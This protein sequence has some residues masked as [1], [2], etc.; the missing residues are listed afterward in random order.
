MSLRRLSRPRAFPLLLAVLLA[1]ATY[2]PVR[3]AANPEIPGTPLPPSGQITSA[4]GGSVFDLVYAVDVPAASVL[5]ISLRG[6][7]G[8]E[9]GLYLFGEGSTSILTALPL[10]SSAKPGG[11]QSVSVRFIRASTVYINVNGR[12][13]NRAYS[14]TL[15]ASILRDETPPIII[16]AV[17]NSRSQSSEV[18][19]AVRSSDPISGITGIKLTDELGGGDGEWVSFS[20]SA[21]HCTAL[22]EGDGL[23]SLTL[24]TRNGVNLTSAAY[25]LTTIIDDTV[26]ELISVSPTGNLLLTARG[27]ISWRFDSAITT[28]VPLESAVNIFNQAGRVIN[29]TVTR[30]ADRRSVTWTPLSNIPAGNV[31]LASLGAVRDAAGNMLDF[32]DT[33]VITRKNVTTL[34]ITSLAATSKPRI[35]ISASSNLLGESVIIELRR[36]RGWVP[37]R[38]VTLTATTLSVTLN[39]DAGSAVRASFTGSDRLAP[40]ASAKLVIE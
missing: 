16:S 8:A 4:V 6:E 19:V 21:V 32:T 15:L 7:P 28:I 2:A 35:R 10:A 9:L 25:R 11:V 20:G 39:A 12:N 26:P 40:S 3:A 22:A 30:S 18:C 38:T 37:L 24:R 1:C 34:R 29:G 5:A 23:R 17:S 13:S 33:R 31:L 27:A 36:G 14:F